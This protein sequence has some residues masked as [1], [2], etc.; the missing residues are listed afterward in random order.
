MFGGGSEPQP[1]PFLSGGKQAGRDSSDLPWSLWGGG[2]PRHEDAHPK[3]RQG[4]RQAEVLS[5]KG[6]GGS[7][8]EP[9]KREQRVYRERVLVRVYDLGKTVV[10]K[11]LNRMT[12]SMGA[13]HSGVEI[14]GREWSFGMTF[15]EW[16]TGITWNDPGENPDHTYLETLSM[17]YT[18]KSPTEVWQLI[19]EMKAQWRGHTYH[20][21]TRNCHHFSDAFCQKLGVARIPP[22]L[23]DLAGTGAATVEFLDTADSGYDGGEAISDFFSSM[24]RGLYSALSWESS[25]A[26]GPEPLPQPKGYPQD[27]WNGPQRSEPRHDPFSV[28]RR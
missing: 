15:D 19:E 22:W 5:R 8:A 10:T 14:Y 9:K 28:L 26:K 4:A 3:S 2:S 13:F 11:G 18:S 1:D 17:G 16:S 24:K 12:K 6:G 25:D 7:E 27:E 20:L 23:N 21:L